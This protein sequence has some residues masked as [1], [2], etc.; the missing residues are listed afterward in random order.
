MTQICQR[1]IRHAAALVILCACD[2]TPLH[3]AKKTPL[4]PTS[5]ATENARLYRKL[6]ADNQ[7]FD[8]ATTLEIIDSACKHLQDKGV[9]MQGKQKLL[10]PTRI[11]KR[12]NKILASVAPITHSSCTPKS[13]PSAKPHNLPHTSKNNAKK[14][15]CSGGGTAYSGSHTTCEMRESFHDVQV[16]LDSV[17]DT[18]DNITTNANCSEIDAT[19]SI[20]EDVSNRL[21]CSCDT[22]IRQ[23]D[24][25]ASGGT[26]T[27]NSSG[28]YC[29][30]ENLQEKVYYAPAV[31]NIATGNVTL[32][33]QGHTID[34]GGIVFSCIAIASVS[35][36]GHVYIKNGNVLN[37]I[38]GIN[39]SSAT[40]IE[41]WTIDN[42]HVTG[43]MTVGINASGV[44]DGVVRFVSV[45]GCSDG[46]KIDATSVQSN[47]IICNCICRNNETGFRISTHTGSKVV[48]KNC[49]SI[50]NIQDNFL[51]ENAN[52][53]IFTDCL[54][55][56]S[57]GN[58]YQFSSMPET[59]KIILQGCMSFK[60]QT[61]SLSVSNYLDN[62]FECALIRDCV[63]LAPQDDSCVDVLGAKLLNISDT[64][65]ALSDST[66]ARDCFHVAGIPKNDNSILSF[67]D[68][69]AIGHGQ[70]NC[71]GFNIET[72]STYGTV[73][74]GI[75]DL[76]LER[77]LAQNIGTGF[78]LNNQ[79]HKTDKSAC[80]II[81]ECSALSVKRFG[82][83][84][85]GGQKIYGTLRN[86]LTTMHTDAGS[87][88][89]YSAFFLDN[90]GPSLSLESCT[91]I[92]I[93]SP[94]DGFRASSTTSQLIFRGNTASG[95]SG[96]GFNDLSPGKNAFFN[97]L[98]RDNTTNFSG[99][100]FT[101]TG[102]SQGAYFVANAD[103]SAGGIPAFQPAL[104][105]T[106]GYWANVADPN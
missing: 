100:N 53:V 86:C 62:P 37:A 36:G 74:N 50:K 43:P 88:T 47:T 79:Y 64:I 30:G 11:M 76:N 67:R 55:I 58:G 14:R 7:P 28:T 40:G 4:D 9:L 38:F 20:L 2:I 70:A 80:T 25:D 48:L 83:E 49:I 85:S 63:F 61:T 1:V 32:D 56:A 104:A 92:G 29:I 68:C 27:I 24:I 21:P 73:N 60:D 71:R 93:A 101:P 17:Q 46:I 13:L 45:D 12:V 44:N 78:R 98:A 3:A 42:I 54:S 94:V 66:G 65:A 102:G 81:R 103:G 18:I 57:A 77:C 96:T 8:M 72:L 84:L 51:T 91:A 41:G 26:Y 16:T 52:G 10:D 15:N 75:I 22:V 99:I 106:M 23:A 97:N 95:F 82:F 39:I 5:I 19:Q 87:G 105:A 33:L 31:I 6:S 35:D 89:D 59:A 90:D 69:I 34:G